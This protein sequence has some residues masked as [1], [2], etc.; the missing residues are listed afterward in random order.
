MTMRWYDVCRV[1]SGS[2]S[3]VLRRPRWLSSWLRLLLCHLLWAIMVF[4]R[5]CIGASL[6]EYVILMVLMRNQNWNLIIGLLELSTSL[7]TATLVL[8]L[9]VG[10]KLVSVQYSLPVHHDGRRVLLLLLD[11]SCSLHPF[12]VICIYIF[13]DTPSCGCKRNALHDTLS[14]CTSCACLGIVV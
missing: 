9:Q 6:E 13:A 10:N 1:P 11:L 12:S 2:G 4:V 14:Y 8:L 5:R 7:L 3:L